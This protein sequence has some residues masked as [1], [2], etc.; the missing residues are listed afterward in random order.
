MEVDLGPGHI[1][2]DGDPAP[3]PKR[4][5]PRP[6]FGPCLLWPNGC[7]D[8]GAT[9]YRGRRRSRRY[10]V[11][12]TPNSP[13]TKKENG[14]RAAP[15]FRP[16]YCGQTA[17]WIKMPLGTEVG[18]G[19]QLPPPTKKGHSNPH[20]G[21]CQLWP[22]GWM[23]QDVIGTKVGLGPG[24]IVLDGDPA[25]PTKKGTAHA[26]FGPYLLWPNCRPSQLLLSTCRG[27]WSS[28]VATA[29]GSG[30]YI[31]RIFLLIFALK[32]FLQRL[33]TGILQTILCYVALVANGK[34]ICP[35]R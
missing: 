5:Q 16:I 17:E 9:W 14:G 34:L 7:M 4:A 10:C 28:P 33:S 27:R 22:K 13:P 29:R 2:L 8:Q 32:H 30:H 26:I 24:H 21:P 35:F 20:F 15:T 31:L 18:R 12:Q 25:P 1:L 6:I 11:R 23:D 3:S 19:I